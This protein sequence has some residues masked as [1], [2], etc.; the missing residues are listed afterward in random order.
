MRDTGFRLPTTN[1]K[2]VLLN[3]V[4]R[5]L[6]RLPYIHIYIFFLFSFSALT[7]THVQSLMLVQV[8]L[9][10]LSCYVQHPSDFSCCHSQRVVGNRHLILIDHSMLW[11]QL[12]TETTTARISGSSSELVMQHICL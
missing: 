10:K 5:V 9:R 12:N 2:M 1:K 3:S 6:E 11:Q 4:M 7:L 8:L